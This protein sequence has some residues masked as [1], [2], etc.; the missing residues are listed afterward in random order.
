MATPAGNTKEEHRMTRIEKRNVGVPVV[1]QAIGGDLR[2][3]F[4]VIGDTVGSC[5]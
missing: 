3:E 2:L 5:I 1:I 4:Q